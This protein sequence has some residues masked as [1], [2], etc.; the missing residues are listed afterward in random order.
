M[1]SIFSPSGHL[2]HFQFLFGI[3]FFIYMAPK[4]LAQPSCNNYSLFAP[5]NELRNRHIH[6]TF[7][8]FLMFYCFVT[9]N[10]VDCWSMPDIY[11]FFP[12]ATISSCGDLSWSSPFAPS[13][14]T[15]LSVCRVHPHHPGSPVTLPSETGPQEA[16]RRGHPKR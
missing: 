3:C 11:W 10:S 7:S 15:P 2:T 16:I 9:T 1:F 8:C 4:G 12:F 6:V 13:S 14:M 5:I